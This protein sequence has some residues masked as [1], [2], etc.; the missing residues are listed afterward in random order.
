MP[1]DF[2]ETARRALQFAVALAAHSGGK[3]TLFYVARTRGADGTKSTMRLS[4]TQEETRS[5]VEQLVEVMAHGDI[6]RSV[7][8]RTLVKI[9]CPDTEFIVRAARSSNSDLIVMGTHGYSWWRHLGRTAA[10]ERVVRTAPCAVL[11]VPEQ[12]LT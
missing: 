1:I 2:T 10:T 4:F 8:F 3:I 5:L 11:S 12:I 6:P 7:E 9:G